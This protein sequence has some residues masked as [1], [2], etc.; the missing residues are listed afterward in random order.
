MTAVATEHIGENLFGDNH[1]SNGVDIKSEAD[2]LLG[3]LVKRFV[4]TDNSCAVNEDI[5]ATAILFD[6]LVGLGYELAISDVHLIN[7]YARERSKFVGNSLYR[8]LIDIPNNQR[9][10]P[11]LKHHSAHNLSN[12]RSTTS[13]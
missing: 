5:Y 13:D 1:R 10:S 3:L 8:L 7:M 2:V 12:P 6:L 9:L 4:A 11:F